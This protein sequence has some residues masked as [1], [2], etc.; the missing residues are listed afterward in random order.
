MHHGYE[1]IGLFL[2]LPLFLIAARGQPESRVLLQYSRTRKPHPRTLA[3]LIP[4]PGS[5]WID[6]AA[7][8]PPSSVAR[9][10]R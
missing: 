2:L 3:K 7:L 1:Y 8:P 5:N 9:L 4:N 6:S 10:M